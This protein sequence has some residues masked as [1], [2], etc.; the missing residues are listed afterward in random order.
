MDKTL[1]ISG[2]IGFIPST[3]NIIEGGVEAEARQALDNMGHILRGG[4][5]QHNLSVFTFVLQCGAF[6]SKIL[7]QI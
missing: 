6:S 2:Q 3:M 4:I 5:H 7:N 1:Y